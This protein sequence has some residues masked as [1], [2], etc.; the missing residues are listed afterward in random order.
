MIHLFSTPIL[1]EK[2][3]TD[4][5][6]KLYTTVKTYSENNTT[7][8]QHEW[9]CNINT[10]FADANIFEINEFKP[11]E[12]ILLKYVDQWFK[13]MKYDYTSDDFK[14][15][16]WINYSNRDQYQEEHLHSGEGIILSGTVF[17]NSD[18]STGYFSI[19]H[20]D[21]SSVFFSRLNTNNNLS[22]C[23]RYKIPPVPGEVVI[24]PCFM[25]HGV[26]YN[27]SDITRITLSFNVR[28]DK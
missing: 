25:K 7:T 9:N 16:G 14:L 11:I 10:T 19:P 23:T 6:N 18:P 12:Q 21:V 27:N 17:I 2:L 13:E 15:Q 4:E 3:N 5:F 8:K 22:L 26:E 28:F 1:C 20:P 24:F